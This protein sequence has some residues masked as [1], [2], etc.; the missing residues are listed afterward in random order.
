MAEIIET[1]AK[2]I[3]GKIQEYPIGAQQ[4][5]I[6]AL[7]NSSVNNLEE[8][9]LLGC[10]CFT[11]SYQDENN[12]R[13]VIKEFHGETIDS[14]NFSGFYVLKT[15]FYFE[16][17]AIKTYVN[18]NGEIESQIILNVFDLKEEDLPQ[19]AKNILIQEDELYFQKHDGEEISIAKKTT[20]LTILDNNNR[21]LKSFVTLQNN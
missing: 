2:T 11:T 21:V 7:R 6:G 14:V 15:I 20:E 17:P 5:F 12:H 18:D 9:L 3:D 19:D 8:Q 4:R 13:I 1:I 10:D 16:F